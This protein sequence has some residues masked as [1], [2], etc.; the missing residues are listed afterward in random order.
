MKREVW[1]VDPTIA[2]DRFDLLTTVIRESVAVPRFTM[3]LVGGFAL[4]AMILAAVG[5]YGVMAYA[6]C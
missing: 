1:A 2:M 4:L 6:V 3:Q 5:I